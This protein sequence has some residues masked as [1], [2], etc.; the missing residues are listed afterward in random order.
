MWDYYN[1]KKQDNIK[2]ERSEEHELR[3]EALYFA[4]KM[5]SQIESYFSRKGVDLPKDRLLKFRQTLRE[6]FLEAA[7]LE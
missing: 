4:E 2:K 6:L 3:M 7:G 1:I 5:K